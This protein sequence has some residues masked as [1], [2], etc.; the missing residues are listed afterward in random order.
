MKY[1]L[2]KVEKPSLVQ[3]KGLCFR[4]GRLGTG[5]VKEQGAEWYLYGLRGIYSS[6]DA[7]AS[8]MPPHPSHEFSRA[9][10]F[11]EC[12]LLHE[13]TLNANSATGQ[14]SCMRGHQCST[15]LCPEISPIT[16]LSGLSCGCKACLGSV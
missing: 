4:A 7:Q 16:L 15:V 11:S 2:Y 3:E 13:P 8:Q 14:R 5:K 10:C 9:A 12:G 1:Y 6:R